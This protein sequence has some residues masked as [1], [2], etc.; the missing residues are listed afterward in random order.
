MKSG[1]RNTLCL[2]ITVEEMR[3][4]RVLKIDEFVSFSNMNIQKLFAFHNNIIRYEFKR[5][6][7]KVGIS[8]FHNVFTKVIS[9]HIFRNASK[10]CFL[11]LNFVGN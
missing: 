3:I 1:K 2:E 11:K 7:F 4:F 5:V 10:L 8:N 6:Q 9:N